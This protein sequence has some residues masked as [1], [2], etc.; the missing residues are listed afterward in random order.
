MG[1]I[2]TILNQPDATENI[3]ETYK[4]VL[5]NIA[6]L[7]WDE[8]SGHYERIQAKTFATPTK[9][10][11]DHLLLQEYPIDGIFQKVDRADIFDNV[12]YL[13]G[14]SP[15]VQKIV[16]HRLVTEFFGGKIWLPKEKLTLDEFDQLFNFY[17]NPPAPFRLIKFDGNDVYFDEPDDKPSSIDTYVDQIIASFN[18]VH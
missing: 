6:K 13:Q 4:R 1:V 11:L 12:S 15:K 10:M 7:C 16:A 2:L 18:A 8:K 3:S 17:A 5:L 9:E 14:L